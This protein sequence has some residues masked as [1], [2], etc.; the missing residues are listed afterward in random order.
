M[1]LALFIE[2]GLDPSLGTQIHQKM[3]ERPVFSYLPRPSDVG[4]L[5][6]DHIP[7]VGVPREEVYEWA[8]SSWNAWSEH[9]SRVD[10]WLKQSGLRDC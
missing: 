5:K 2:D 3:V 6:F 1:T 10:A 7:L 9:H 4:T 8:K